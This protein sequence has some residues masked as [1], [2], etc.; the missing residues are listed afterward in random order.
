[1]NNHVTGEW[2]AFTSLTRA[3]FSLLFF[4]GLLPMQIT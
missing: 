2:H 4:S 3:A 1:M